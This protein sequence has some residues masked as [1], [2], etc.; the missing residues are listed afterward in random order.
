M[1][2]LVQIIDKL[3]SG[4]SLLLEEQE[5]Y[6]EALLESPFTGLV[7][8]VPEV[9]DDSGAQAKAEESGLYWNNA[10]GKMYYIKQ[11]QKYREDDIAEGYASL[12]S[13]TLIQRL[14]A[15]AIP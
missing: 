13:R 15:A 9:A 10:T 2:E 14:S 11:S 5:I 6:D 7:P 4:G 1:S 12:I 8:Y 3:K